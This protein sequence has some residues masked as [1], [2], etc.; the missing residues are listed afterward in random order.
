MGRRPDVALLGLCVLAALAGC[1][2]PAELR[3]ARVAVRAENLTVTPSTGPVTHVLVHNPGSRTFRGRLVADFPR[4][5]KMNRS[6]Q[7][8]AIPPGQT[9]RVAFAI[10][11]G[12]DAASNSY[13]VRLRVLGGASTITRTQRIVCASAP[14]FKPTI[15]G[16]IEDWKDALPAA[17]LTRGKKTVISTYWSRRS[18]SVLVAVEEDALIAMPDGD[19]AGGFDAVQIAVA[20]REAKT[21][22]SPAGTAQRYEFLLAA[23]KA[24]GRCFALLRYGQSVAVAKRPRRL[25][26][27]ELAAADVAVAR[28]GGVT[29]YECSIPLKAMPKIRPEPGREFCF[30]VL[31]H[32]PDGTGLRDWGRAAGLWPWQRSRLAWCSWL[33]AKWPDRPPFDNKIEWGFCSSKY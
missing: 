17:F 26:G 27:L 28:S 10:E 5:W 8:L 29:Y 11:R 20:P 1:R 4:G 12:T 14:Y 18:F 33:G 32:D 13:A 30:S 22:E 7:D 6:Q 21:P 25:G 9:R 24:G 15:D 19:G 23:T 3:G 2:G 31:V 16:R